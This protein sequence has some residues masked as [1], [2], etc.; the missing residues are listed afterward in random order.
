MEKLIRFLLHFFGQLLIQ[1]IIIFLDDL[2][3]SSDSLDDDSLDETKTPSPEHIVPDGNITDTEQPASPMLADKVKG[4]IKEEPFDEAAVEN[5]AKELFG[6]DLLFNQDDLHN[7]EFWNELIETSENSDSLHLEGQKFLT[8]DLVE[9]ES[10]IKME[11]PS[12]ASNFFSSAA[13]HPTLT[14]F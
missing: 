6:S 14:G 5:A 4:E 7:E 8:D 10:S 11:S 13:H 1:F 9:M 2:S 12:P 3:V